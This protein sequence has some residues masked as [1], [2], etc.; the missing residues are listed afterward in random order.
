MYVEYTAIQCRLGDD[1]AAV[2]PVQAIS[3]AT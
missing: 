2:P 1:P 3:I